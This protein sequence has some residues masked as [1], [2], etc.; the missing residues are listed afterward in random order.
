MPYLFRA[1]RVE[2]DAHRRQRA[3]ADL[4]SPTPS[5]CDSFCASTVEAAS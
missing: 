1:R 5:T 3:A 2:L 4:T